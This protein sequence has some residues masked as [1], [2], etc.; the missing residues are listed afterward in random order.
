M[1]PNI[2]PDRKPGIGKWSDDDLL[3]FVQSG[4]TLDGDSA[5]GAMAA[6]IDNV[7]SRLTKSDQLAIVRYVLSLPPI[8]NP[9]QSAKSRSKRDPYEY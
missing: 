3:F 2:T 9:L 5:G 8:E 4:L 7:T 6:V 1:V